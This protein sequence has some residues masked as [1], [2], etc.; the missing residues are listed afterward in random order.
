MKQLLVAAAYT[1]FCYCFVRLS[2]SY[3]SQVPATS[4]FLARKRRVKEIRNNLYSRVVSNFALPQKNKNK[5]FI[6]NLLFISPYISNITQNKRG[7]SS[8]QEQITCPL[9]EHA[10]RH[11]DYNRTER[12]IS[13]SAFVFQA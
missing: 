5:A 9:I 6:K 4:K 10:D 11:I 3:V 12:T 1:I 13:V 7:C 8:Q 2:I